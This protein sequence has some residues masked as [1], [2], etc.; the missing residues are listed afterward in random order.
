MDDLAQA[1]ALLAHD[2]G[3]ELLMY[4]LLKRTIRESIF[5]PTARFNMESINN[6]TFID[7]FRFSKAEFWSMLTQFNLSSTIILPCRTRVTNVEAVLILLRRLSYPNRWIELS[8]QFGRSKP[9]LCRIFQ[10]IL[11]TL[12]E[13]Y[14]EKIMFDTKI[15]QEYAASSMT[16]I[17]K[18]SRIQLRCMGFVD[19][20]VR[21]IARPTLF[22]R[23]AYNGHKRVHALKFQSIVMT[24]RLIVSLNGPI[25]GRRHDVALLRESKLG[26]KMLAAGID[27]VIYGD[28]AYPV[29][30]W[31]VGLYK[32]ANTTARQKEFNRRMSKV[33]VSVEWCFGDLIRNWA[34][35]DFKKNPRFLSLLSTN[36][37]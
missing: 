13:K 27:A 28:P 15:M 23:Q 14:K 1:L 33:R 18:R 31:L 29:L 3:D 2:Q 34:F 10:F 22:Q 25:E 12:Y 9:V 16:A 19:G 11:S 32:S 36:S 17:S 26:E 5:I 37:T 21:P 35:L 7:L 8:M 30:N 24:N 6:A 20:T 4:M